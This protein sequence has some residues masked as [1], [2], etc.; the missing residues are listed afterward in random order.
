M[1][2]VGMIPI[3][4]MKYVI[5]ENYETQSIEQKS[6]LIQS[7]CQQI[8]DQVGSSGYIRNVSTSQQVDKQLVQLASIYNGRVIIVNS[9]FR[10]VRDTYEIDEDKV[11]ISEEV[12]QCFLAPIRQITMKKM[13]FWN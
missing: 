3:F 10:I 1:L 11:M 13:N 8:V 7:Q 12:L 2:L 4:L 6:A 9:S 5:L